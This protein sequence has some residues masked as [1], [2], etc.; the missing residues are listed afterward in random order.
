[1]VTG[2]S[3]LY[4]TEILDKPTSIR[5]KHL[6]MKRHTI[7]TFLTCYQRVIPV[8]LRTKYHL[9]LK[10]IIFLFGEFNLKLVSH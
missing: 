9:K 10:E 8:N 7:K 6:L 3:M 1:M 4:K 2:S 5:K